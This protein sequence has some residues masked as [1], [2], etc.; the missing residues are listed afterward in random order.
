[1]LKAIA[2]AV[3]MLMAGLQAGPSDQMFDDLKM[4][5]SPE[6]AESIALDIWAAWLESG[7][8]TVDLLMERGVAAQSVGDLELARAF[9]DRAILIEPDYAEAWN[10][11]ATIF[12]QEENL[13]EALRDINET[14][15]REP[16]HFGAWLG[17]GIVLERLGAKDE[18]LTAYRE[19]LAIYPHLERARSAARRL[20]DAVDGTAL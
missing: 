6:E 3:L 12:L 16:R 8:P 20:E 5:P 15:A 14:L 17:L 19:A 2:S 13:A 18:A 10:R 11:R 7:S 4:A 9:Y 1:M